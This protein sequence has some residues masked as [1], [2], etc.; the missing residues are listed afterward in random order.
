MSRGLFVT[1]T[2]TGV[3]KTIATVA[4]LHALRHEGLR[5]VG[6]KPVASGCQP[7]PQGWRN[8]DALMLQAA[9]EPRP[10]YDLVNPY[11]LPDATAPQIAASLP[12][13]LEELRT[14]LNRRSSDRSDL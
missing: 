7:T 13:E 10:D 2:D 4:M 11:A 5:A 14:R 3:G 8:D 1:G 12:Q 9:S 6:M